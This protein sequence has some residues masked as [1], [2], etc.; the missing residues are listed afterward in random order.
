[1]ES[2]VAIASA[3]SFESCHGLFRVLLDVESSRVH[4]KER[5]T[6]RER[7]KEREREKERKKERK[8]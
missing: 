4:V 3:Q 7:K 8:K 2:K 5:K 1:L 6:D